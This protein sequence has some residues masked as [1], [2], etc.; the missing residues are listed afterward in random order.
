MKSKTAP[1]LTEFHAVLR[2]AAERAEAARDRREAEKM[3]REVAELAE[4]LARMP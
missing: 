1:D 2:R 4:E 3:A